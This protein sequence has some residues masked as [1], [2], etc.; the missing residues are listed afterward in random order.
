MSEYKLYY[1]DSGSS[2]STK[3]SVDGVVSSSYF[4]SVFNVPTESAPKHIALVK[5]NIPKSYY[6]VN[7]TNNEFTLTLNNNSTT[8][9]LTSGCYNQRSFATELGTKLDLGVVAL[10]ETGT[11]TISYPTNAQ[12]QTGKYTYT[13]NG[14]YA[15]TLT[16]TTELYACCGFAAASSNVFSGSSGSYTI[17]ATQPSNLQLVSSLFIHADCVVNAGDNGNSILDV[18][19]GSGNPD[20]SNIIWENEN[21]INGKKDFLIAGN[22]VEIKLL[23][24]NNNYIN[25]NGSDWNLVIAIW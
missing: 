8:I 16:F 18:V 5:C 23:D 4:R 20:Y 14:I 7:S 9:T 25:L 15:P 12:P 3:L 11:F 2:F 19:Y 13:F 10:G 17:S 1:L 24:F 21:F 22:S 6:L